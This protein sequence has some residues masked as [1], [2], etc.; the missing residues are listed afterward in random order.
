MIECLDRQNP[1]QFAAKLMEWL[2][3]GQPFYKI[4][5][6]NDTE[7]REKQYTL[8]HTNELVDNVDMIAVCNVENIKDHSIFGYWNKKKG[9]FLMNLWTR[10]IGEQLKDYKYKEAF[11]R[12]TVPGFY[13]YNSAFRNM[14]RDIAAMAA[15]YYASL[16]EI[17]ITD[18]EDDWEG[19]ASEEWWKMYIHGLENE[20][21]E[22]FLQRRFIQQF[23]KDKTLD[24]DDI[25]RYEELPY[26]A[27]KE[28]YLQKQKEAIQAYICQLRNEDSITNEYFAKGVKDIIHQEFIK[29]IHRIMSKELRLYRAVQITK[30]KFVIR[31]GM[32]TTRNIASAVWKYM[33]QER[34]VKSVVIDF[35]G[36]ANTVFAGEQVQCLVK[37]EGLANPNGLIYL[38]DKNVIQILKPEKWKL[39]RVDIW[40]AIEG[41]QIKRV[42]YKGKV[43]Y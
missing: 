10:T 33:N 40:D 4:A 2:Q 35:E 32:E 13:T 9:F 29:I 19:M 7:D 17:P 8:I 12:I 5:L 37:A 14:T 28:I 38:F 3:S 26:L 43:I 42:S 41:S 31:E 1:N 39:K 24:R 25:H 16:P 34:G 21:L 6:D 23:P 27:D 15:S 20:S 22:D 18:T 36:R 11:E 30:K